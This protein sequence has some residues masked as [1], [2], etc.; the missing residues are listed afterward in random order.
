ME[1]SLPK[2]LDGADEPVT[3]EELEQVVRRAAQRR[4]ASLVA[5]AAA[6]LAIGSVGGALARGPAEDRP[7]ALAGPSQQASSVL[8]SPG[9]QTAVANGEAIGPKQ[10][11]KPLF[12]REPN[13]V[14]IRAYLASWKAEKVPGAVVCGPD[15]SIH[16]ELSNGAAVTF[17]MAPV[18]PAASSA[19]GARVAVAGTGT[20]GQEEGE[21][22]T[23]V[24]VQAS[25]VAK[26]RVTSGPATD[27]MEPKDGIAILALPGTGAATIQGLS[28]DGKVVT[29][30]SVGQPPPPPMDP[31]CMPPPCPPEGEPP[32]PADPVQNADEITK[33]KAEVD[34]AA[35]DK[36]A[37]GTASPDKA[38]E[39]RAKGIADGPVLADGGVACGPVD[40]PMPP[41]TV[42][43]G[44]PSPQRQPPTMATTST[45]TPNAAP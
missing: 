31:A 12:R 45:A 44:G 35:A 20:F 11:L 34:K 7:G 18:F 40:L 42:V 5:G 1:H 24:V 13:G 26:V 2:V 32:T 39:A 15:E 38:V 8:P 28:A 27:T 4:R 23:W 30:G 3:V 9:E 14:A 37:S 17:A 25:E 19:G 41:P 22:A 10:N 29:T 43:R 16:G 36:A 21:A 33:R 6:L